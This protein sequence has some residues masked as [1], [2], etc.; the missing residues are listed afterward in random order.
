MLKIVKAFL[1]MSRDICATPFRENVEE[2]LRWT[3]G[4]RSRAKLS[5]NLPSSQSGM[6]PHSQR[7]R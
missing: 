4:E 5:A 3:D 6:C 1:V 2:S 7:A